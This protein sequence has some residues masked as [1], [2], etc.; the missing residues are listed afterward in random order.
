MRD[1]YKYY[2]SLD[3]GGFIQTIRG[4]YKL[5]TTFAITSNEE[6]AL[7]SAQGDTWKMDEN[8]GDAFHLV[9]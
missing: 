5:D 1:I 3:E 6:D 7:F 9:S 8:D 2:E 4:A